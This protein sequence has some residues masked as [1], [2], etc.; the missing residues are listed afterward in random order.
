MSPPD[1]SPSRGT[2]APDKGT[3]FAKQWHAEVIAVRELLVADGRISPEDWSR[4]LGAELDRRHA[5]GAPD[6]DATYYEAFLAVLEQV[7][8]AGR[9]ATPSEI[10]RCEADWR[11]AYLS[12]PHGQPVVLKDR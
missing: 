8:A 1:E 11:A 4:A 9:L 10:D 5:S 7:T 6:T 12:T 2:R 3:L